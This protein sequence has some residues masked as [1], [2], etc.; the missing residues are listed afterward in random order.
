[1]ATRLTDRQRRVIDTIRGWI[2]EH[3]IP[4]TIRELGR[5]LGIKSL[6]GVT[7]HLDALS[8]KGY[9][10]RRRGAR[11]LRL[12]GAHGMPAMPVHVPVLG[13][14]AAGQPILAQEHQEGMLMVDSSWLKGGSGTEH[15]ALRVRGRSM[16]GAGILDGDYVIVRQQPEVQP[17]EIV[18]A[19]IGEDATVK[20]FAKSGESIRLEPANPA[21]DPI[22]L[23]AD[24]PAR[25]LG[26]VVAVVRQL[27]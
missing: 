10:I 11:S 18:A 15:F 27:P 14:I 5:S 2:S 8:K 20:R 17:G 16:I 3:G 4:P 12:V 22:V 1:M 24:H 23:D 9:L 21:M 7:T 26:K 6:R 25:I 19:L 13:H